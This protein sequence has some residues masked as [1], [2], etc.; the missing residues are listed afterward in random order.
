MFVCNDSDCMFVSA[1]LSLSPPPPTPSG[2]LRMQ[3]LSPLIWEPEAV[4]ESEAVK[5]WLGQNIAMHALPT[6]IDFFL[7]L[8]STFSVHLPSFVPNTLSIFSL[9]SDGADAGFRIELPRNASRLRN[10]VL[11]WIKTVNQ[12]YAWDNCLL[13]IESLQRARLNS[14]HL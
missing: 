3:K 9:A 11:L 8:I 6:A 1:C 2:V 7:A 10:I 13:A 14:R 5:P 12:T 4:K